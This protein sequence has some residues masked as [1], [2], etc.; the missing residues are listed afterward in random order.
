LPDLVIEKIDGGQRFTIRQGKW[1]PLKV[2]LIPIAVA[3]FLTG[4][5]AWLV[6]TGSWFIGFVVGVAGGLCFLLAIICGI[7]LLALSLSLKEKAVFSVTS[8]RIEVDGRAVPVPDIRSIHHGTPR[9]S[10]GV[11]IGL[12]GDLAGL[13]GLA[14][15]GRSAG[16]WL[17]VGDRAI[18]LARQIRKAEAA[19]IFNAIKGIVRLA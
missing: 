8:D 6:N 3:L 4:I 17:R 9:S 16:V 1:T 13:M 19:E 15:A 7:L 10:S 18:Y 12:A 14:L 5:G 11:E 2:A